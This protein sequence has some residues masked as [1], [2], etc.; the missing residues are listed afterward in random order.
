MPQQKTL[1][2]RKVA[3]RKIHAAKKKAFSKVQ[4]A[5]EAAKPFKPTDL[6]ALS[7]KYKKKKK[8]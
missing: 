6:G 4:G 1:G 8:T 5:T 7:R 2:Q 3:A